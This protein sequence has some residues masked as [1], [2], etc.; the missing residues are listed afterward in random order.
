MLCLQESPDD[1]DLVQKIDEVAVLG[2]YR[3]PLRRRCAAFRH[4]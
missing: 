1:C 4:A 2:K 3:K